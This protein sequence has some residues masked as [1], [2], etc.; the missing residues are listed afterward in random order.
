VCA[1]LTALSIYLRVLQLARRR[2]R[3]RKSETTTQDEANARTT[4]KAENSASPSIQIKQP[5][6]RQPL[7][8][9]IEQF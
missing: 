2:T 8:I 7:E 5:T 4:R 9:K 3:R 6:A 1:V